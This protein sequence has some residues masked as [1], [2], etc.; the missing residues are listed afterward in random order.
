ML[1]DVAVIE[2]GERDRGQGR[3]I[4]DLEGLVASSLLPILFQ[5]A[6][7]NRSH[8]VK[9]LADGTIAYDQIDSPSRS[10]AMRRDCHACCAA[11]ATAPTTA[12]CSGFATGS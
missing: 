3:F 8:L 5:Y 12:G 6:E 10:A 2:P 11:V 1:D 4:L 7:Q 9:V